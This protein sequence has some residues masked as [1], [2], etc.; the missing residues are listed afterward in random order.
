MSRIGALI[1]EGNDQYASGN[2]AIAALTFR[3]AASAANELGDIRSY[4]NAMVWAAE[5]EH[6][7]GRYQEALGLLL[8]IYAEKANLDPSEQWLYHKLHYKCLVSWNPDRERIEEAIQN[9]EKLACQCEAPP[10][11][12]P[13]IRMEY[14][15]LIGRF[16]D[17]IKFG[18]QAFL[19]KSSGGGYLGYGIAFGCFEVCLKTRRLDQAE[20]WLGAVAECKGDESPFS[21]QIEA[22]V[23]IGRFRLA[24]AQ[25]RPVADL[26]RHLAQAEMV[27]FAL[28]DPEIREQLMAARVRAELLDKGN[29]DPCKT[30]H[31]ARTA[32]RGGL[33]RRSMNLMW[34]FNYSVLMLDYRLGC[35]RYSMGIDPID[36]EYQQTLLLISQQRDALDQSRLAKVVSAVNVASYYGRRLDDMLSC[37]WRQQE[38]ARRESVI[39][40]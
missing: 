31:P 40:G 32:L 10:Q 15:Y 38:I 6:A 34:H 30:W 23:A 28:D 27:A 1:E 9:L 33:G 37:N 8:E 35:L 12:L 29:G 7:T 4:V 11:D 16:D 13:A 14:N 5:A 21:R 17:A 20:H 25:G 22:A 36:D 39:G 18:E 19:E 24:Q 2:L 3:Q 26:R